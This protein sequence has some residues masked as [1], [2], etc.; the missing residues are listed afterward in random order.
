MFKNQ[1]WSLS[2]KKEN[3][4]TK[5]S[6]VTNPLTKKSKFQCIDDFVVSTEKI[7]KLFEENKENCYTN[8]EIAKKLHMSSSTVSNVTSRLEA[9]GNI[10]IVG[11]VRVDK[12][13]NGSQIFQHK[14]GSMPGFQR[15][16]ISSKTSE[17]IK[18]TAQLVKEL[19]END[20][21]AT[22]TKND[23]ITILTG[24]S[25]RQIEETIRILVLDETLKVLITSNKNAVYQHMSGNKKGLKVYANSDSNYTTWRKFINESNFNGDIKQFISNLPSNCRLFYSP[26]GII[27]EYL[28]SDLYKILNKVNKKGFVER[29][30]GKHYGK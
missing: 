25:K 26:Q 28:K 23:I 10:R 2:K 3:E 11:N 8:Y 27:V 6:V 18:D 4:N 20:V 5:S 16:T 13:C 14:D 15:T 12:A 19:F 17:K 22:Y 1:P 29:L 9:L 7:R 30:L 21:N 24:C